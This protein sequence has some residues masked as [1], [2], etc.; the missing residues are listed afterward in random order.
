[1]EILIENVVKKPLFYIQVLLR[2]ISVCIHYLTI[3]TIWCTFLI[4]DQVVTVEQRCED[5]V[6]NVKQAPQDCASVESH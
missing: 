2:C 6:V 3:P 4:I 5:E 1:M